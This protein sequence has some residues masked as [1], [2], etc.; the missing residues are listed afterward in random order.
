MD[1]QYLSKRDYL[2]NSSILKLSY[3]D[4]IIEQCDTTNKPGEIKQV[5]SKVEDGIK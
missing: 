4:R 1:L 5:I 3:I 2:D